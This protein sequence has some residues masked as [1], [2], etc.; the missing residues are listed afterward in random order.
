MERY[1]SEFPITRRYAYMNHAAVSPLSL[2]VVKAMEELFQEYSVHG[3]YRYPRWVERV[4]EVRSLLSRL[5]GCA[6]DEIA[7]TGNTS[8]G[9][10]MVAMGLPW[11]SGDAVLIPEPEFPAN[12][13]PW[14]NLE[15]A[16]VQVRFFKRRNGRF[17]ARE[18]ENSLT[19]GTRLISVSSVDF[20]TGFRCDLE[21]LGDFCRRK[22]ILLCVD[23]VQATGVVPVDVKA[24]GIHFLAT[25]SHKWLLSPMGCGVLYVSRELTD[26]LNLQQVGWKSVR[27]SDDFFHID[28]QLKPDAGR[29]EPGSLN[30]P[31]I[32]ALGAAVEMLLEVGIDQVFRRVLA[33]TDRLSEGLRNRGFEIV[34]PLGREERSG[35]LS[36]V[37]TADSERLWSFMTERKVSVSIRGS[38]IRLSPHFY[39]NKSDIDRFFRV[40]DRFTADQ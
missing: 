38:A 25:G 21:E 15:Q 4:E 24:C 7:F 5:I 19:S 1:R 17:G 6:S 33:T 11:E 27:S 2:R 26:R 36:F 32:F 8:Q 40:L 29:F 37:P 28:F 31:G 30:I 35:I 13:Y 18:L 23:A 34:T 20:A 12:V 39:N 16:G 10:S 14:M 3:I 9:L 22:G